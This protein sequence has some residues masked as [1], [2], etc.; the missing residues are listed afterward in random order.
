MTAVARLADLEAALA[1]LRARGAQ[2]LVADSRRVQPG[3]AFIAW[4]GAAT[5][6]RGYVAAALQAGAVAALVQAE[7]LEPWLQSGAWPEQAPVAALAGLRQAAG[8]LASAFW[9]HPSARLPLVAVTGTNGKTSTAWWSAQAL[10]AAGRDSGLIGTL[11]IGR[12]GSALRATGLTTPD[13]VTLQGALATFADEGAAAVVLEASSIGIEEGRLDGCRLHTA[14]FT[15]LTQDHLDYHGTMEA[16]WAAKRRLFDWP[17]VRAAVVC[18]DDPWG[19]RLAAELAPRQRAGALDLWTYALQPQA[20]AR[21]SVADLQWQ[22][23][24]MQLHVAEEG[25]TRARWHLPLVG[26]HNAANVLAVVAVLRA[27][28]LDW[29][30]VQ[31]GIGSLTPVPGRMQPAW[32]AVSDGP[33]DDLPQ[34]LVD[35]AHTP[36]A[37]E[38]ALR[39][40]RPLA[41]ARGGRLWCVLGCGGDRDPSKRAPMAA[42][43]EAWADRVVLTSDNPRSE[44]PH[45]IIAQ[46]VQ[47]LLHPARAVLE[48]DRAAAIDWVVRQA[49]PRD[50]V[51]LAGKGHE[52]YQE[53][54]G[55]RHPFCDVQQ[56]RAALRRRREAQG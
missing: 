38:Q 19:Q 15:N 42:A 24:G 16:Y 8:A 2:G 31:A 26:Q 34:V 4:P 5:D 6:A 18:V 39:A 49:E 22:P 50:V 35:Y 1:W 12:P 27:Q 32:D 7:G 53:I 33:A 37:V 11:G 25:H 14:V 48:P 47:G 21:L 10:A 55:V 23:Q 41:Q 9:G 51:L 44:D 13:P 52:Q 45:H 56:A 20:R 29:P 46:M 3:D 43:A 40:L 30:A 54:A 36:D 17:G 28:G